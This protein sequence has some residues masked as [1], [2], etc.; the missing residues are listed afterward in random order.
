SVTAVPAA[1]ALLVPAPK[2]HSETRFS[3]FAERVYVPLLDASLRA[4]VA[5][6]GAAAALVLVMGFAASR[7]GSEFLPNLDEGDIAMHALRIPGTSRS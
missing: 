2:P 4:R 1:V 3:R 5:V 7:M 6:A